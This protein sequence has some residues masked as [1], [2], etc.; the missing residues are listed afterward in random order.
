MKIY[1]V[2]LIVLCSYNIG[3]AS[4]TPS[5]PPPIYFKWTPLA[6][7]AY[8]NVINLRFKEAKSQIAQFKIEE[9]N[10]YIIYYVENY[11]DFFTIYITEDEEEFKRLEKNKDIRLAKVEAGDPNSPYF[12]YLQAAIRVHWG[13]ARLKFSE[14][15]TAFFEA[16]KAFK[17]LTK[18][19]EKFPNFMP[20]KKDLGMM[21]ALVGTIPDNYKWAVE[22]VTSLEGTIEQGCAE[23]EEVL[24]YAQHNDFIFEAETYI[25]YAYLSLFWVKDSKK[26]WAL[27]QKC[28]MKPALSPMATFIFANVSMRT[29]KT[30]RAIELLKNRPQGAAF[31]PFHY[32]DYM[33]GTAKLNR[34]DTDADVYLKKYISRYSGKNFIK[35]SYRR[36]A[37]QSLLQGH[38]Q[39]YHNYMELVKTEGQKV[40]GSDGSAL[41]E[42]NAKEVPHIDL[43]KARLLFDGGYY[44]KAYQLLSQKSSSDFQSKKTKLEYT[45]RLG[46]IAHEMKNY[47]KAILHYQQTIEQGRTA[48]W[49]YACRAALEMGHVYEIQKNK[50]QARKAFERCLD[51]SPSE[52]KFGLHQQAKVGL[53]RLN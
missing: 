22:T 18:N 15:T 21:H 41:K 34:L 16:H 50:E 2:F 49:Y 39:G 11:I 29:G 26:A 44:K 12:L 43:L 36:L 53:S 47:E 33:L 10:N 3:V 6:K 28:K 30:D 7:Q 9:P 14:Y 8:Q 13:A 24:Y 32:L 4:L 19:A 38:E 40:V 45:Y 48:T 1:L 46:R 25:V 35:D 42:A 37:W 52:Y 23:L 5:T 31:F 20:N 27:L 51:I 17:L